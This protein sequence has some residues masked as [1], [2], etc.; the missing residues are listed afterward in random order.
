MSKPQHEAEALGH[1]AE[2]L[3]ELFLTELN[4]MF[5]ARPPYP[6]LGF[7]FFVGFRNE[8]GG[9]NISVIEVKATEKE[10]VNSF[11]VRR[12]LYRMLVHSNLPVV[13]MVADVKRNRLYW[14]APRPE[15]ADAREST[16]VKVRVQAL[17]SAPDSDLRRFLMA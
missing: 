2:L 1:R 6:N 9:V 16:T 11:H 10:V 5:V 12:E 7:D 15:E 13:L 17:E 8:R 14:G 4:P 3:V